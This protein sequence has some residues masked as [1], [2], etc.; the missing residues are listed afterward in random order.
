MTSLRSIASLCAGERCTSIGVVSKAGAE[1][2]Q[3]LSGA[4]VEHGAGV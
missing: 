2:L 3:C 1:A 4:D